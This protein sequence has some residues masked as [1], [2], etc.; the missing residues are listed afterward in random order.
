LS[1]IQ[2][3]CHSHPPQALVVVGLESLNELDDLLVATN[4]SRRSTDRVC[5]VLLIAA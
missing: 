5:C 2:H 1:P 4:R 3:F